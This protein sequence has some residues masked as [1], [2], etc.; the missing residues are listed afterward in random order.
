MPAVRS[1][2]STAIDALVVATV[3]A[4][5]VVPP[6]LTVTTAPG[7]SPDR[8][9]RF[10][11]WVRGD[12]EDHDWK[13]TGNRDDRHADV[14]RPAALTAAALL[15]EDKLTGREGTDSGTRVLIGTGSLLADFLR[16]RGRLPP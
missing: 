1:A 10:M 2:G 3:L 14:R 4:P 5:T 12:A 7:T 9:I 6:C 15:P 8:R 11:H 13:R 16:T